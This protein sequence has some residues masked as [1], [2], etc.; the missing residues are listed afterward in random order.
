MLG[1][2][3]MSKMKM[4]PSSYPTD[5]FYD[6][7][8]IRSTGDKKYISTYYL[9]ELKTNPDFFWALIEHLK[10]KVILP[11]R[12]TLPGEQEGVAQIEFLRNQGDFILPSTNN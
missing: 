12:I 3:S 1:F 4:N 5:Y 7:Y 2:A 11:D 8:L 6:M 9:S 10:T